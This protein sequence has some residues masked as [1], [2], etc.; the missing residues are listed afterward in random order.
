MDV[1]VTLKVIYSVAPISYLGQETG[2]HG[3]FIIL[4]LCL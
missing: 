2:S 4:V 1:V 3:G